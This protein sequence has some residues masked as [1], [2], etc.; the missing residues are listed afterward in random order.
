MA[1]GPGWGEPGFVTPLAETQQGLFVVSAYE[2][3]MDSYLDENGQKV[4]YETSRPVYA[5]ISA[6]DYL[7]STPNYQEFKDLPVPA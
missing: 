4:E 6:E 2:F 5:L 1:D 7:S 3:Y